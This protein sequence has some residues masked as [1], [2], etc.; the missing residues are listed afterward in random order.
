MNVTRLACACLA[1][2]LLSGCGSKNYDISKTIVYNGSI[3]QVTD[4]LQ[5]SES[6]TGVTPDKQTIDLSNRDRDAIED[7]IESNQPLFVKMAFQLDEQE[8]VYQAQNVDS[9]RDYSRMLSRFED[10][11]DD[12]ADLMAEKK[13]DQLKLR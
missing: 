7:L 2:A 6:I 9:Y 3:Y 8:L 4:T 12:I 10:A 5:I 13:T 1:I 11:A